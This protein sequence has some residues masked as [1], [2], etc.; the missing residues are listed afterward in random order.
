MKKGGEEFRCQWICEECAIKRGATW[1]EG[2]IATFHNGKC[3][4]CEREMAVTTPSDFKWGR[5]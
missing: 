1:P 5:K 3:D 2:H 4:L